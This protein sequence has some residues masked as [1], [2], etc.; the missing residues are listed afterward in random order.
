MAGK[1]A[2]SGFEKVDRPL[3][4]A[5]DRPS[6]LF[7]SAETAYPDRCERRRPESR[8]GPRT[9]GAARTAGR[10]RRWGGRQAGAAAAGAGPVR[11]GAGAGRPCRDD[12]AAAAVERTAPLGA[13]LRRVGA[14]RVRAAIGF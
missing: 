11:G 6:S 4:R 13:D 9:G 10:D 7:V 12:G 2:A 3:L 5:V 1:S 14:V 8:S